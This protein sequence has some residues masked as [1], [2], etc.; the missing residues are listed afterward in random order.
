MDKINHRWILLKHFLLEFRIFKIQDGRSDRERSIFLRGSDESQ[1]IAK[2][3]IEELIR[4][5]DQRS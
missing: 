2:Q 4:E 1:D 3:M 5:D